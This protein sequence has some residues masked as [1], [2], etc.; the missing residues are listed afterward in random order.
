MALRLKDV[1][2]GSLLR[3]PL[4]EMLLRKR[5]S[6][7]LTAVGYHRILPT[8]GINFP[9]DAALIS[10]TPD[11]FERELRYLR[12]NLDLLTIKD[13]FEGMK[14]PKE[15]PERPAVLT[16]D[17]GYEDNYRVAYPILK[18][19]GLSA[20]FFI[21]TRIVGTSI[22]PWWDQVACCFKFS[23]VDSFPSPF[24]E[25]DESFRCDALHRKNAAKRFLAKMKE[26]PWPE[27]LVYLENLKCETK[28]DPSKFASSPLFLNWNQAREMQEGGMEFGGHTRTHPV[29]GRISDENFLQ[30][31]I[32]GCFEDM[33][34]ELGVQPLAFSYP[35]GYEFAMS[36]MSDAQI[37]GAGFK[38]SFSYIHKYAP[39]K[40]KSPFRLPRIHSEYGED[41]GAFR[42]G[43]ATAPGFS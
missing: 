17:D 39:R 21:S 11:E 13:L 5:A 40:P 25:R 12:K 33:T 35:E 7:S 18:S 14:S 43:M 32:S 10:A 15:L 36:K 20:C 29:L 3:S 42:I 26:S 41:F 34:T 22:V 24:G 16:F 23:E 38:I 2:K 8:P 28:I 6:Q 30:T 1:V 27:A 4:P 31:E 19:L 9:F 37:L